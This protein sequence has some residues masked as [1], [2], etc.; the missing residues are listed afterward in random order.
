MDRTVG[1]LGGGQLGRMMV[2]EATRMGIKVNILDKAG[3]P[4]VQINATGDHIDGSFTNEEQVLELAKTV[5]VLTCEIEHIQVDALERVEKDNLCAVEPRAYTLRL[6]QNKFL[7]HQHLAEH[8][9][10]VAEF[11]EVKENTVEEIEKIGAQFGYP[12]MLKSQLGAYDGRGNATVKDSSSIEKAVEALGNRALYAEKWAKFK[13]E[14]AVMVVKC[15]NQI[16]SYPTVETAQKDSICSLVFAPARGLSEHVDQAA[17]KL[18]RDAVSTFKG[19]GCYA[20]E[21]FLLENDDVVVN[22]IAPRV[23]N[24]CKFPF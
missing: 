17:Q 11:V 22:E 20:V 5:D 7:Q 15:E 13:M 9:L 6:I 3:C 2:Q 10:P 19:K 16:L 24:S 21:M 23:H 8:N 4:A 1:I 12:M 18:A 14:L